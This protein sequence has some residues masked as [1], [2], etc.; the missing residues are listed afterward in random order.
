MAIIGAVAGGYYGGVWE[1]VGMPETSALVIEK[2]TEV[3]LENISEGGEH[4]N[5]KEGVCK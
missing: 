2:T 1:E 4:E 3:W 5:E